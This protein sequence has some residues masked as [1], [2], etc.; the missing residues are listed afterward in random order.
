M[1]AAA[2]EVSC[3]RVVCV[4]ESDPVCHCVCGSRLKHCGGAITSISLSWLVLNILKDVQGAHYCNYLVLCRV[5]LLEFAALVLRV[6]C[7]ITQGALPSV[8]T[9]CLINN[10]LLAQLSLACTAIYHALISQSR[11][12]L[13]LFEEI[14]GLIF[15]ARRS[16]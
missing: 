4:M 7:V 12:F 5:M 1:E 14:V 15:R 10:S 6:L 11:F 8:Y 9:S 2:E 13:L 3:L 16:N